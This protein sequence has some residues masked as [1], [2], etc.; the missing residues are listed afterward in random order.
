VPERV[1]C[2]TSFFIAL[3]N[4]DDPYHEKGC[5]L[6]FQLIQEK[7][8]FLLHWG[9]VLE[10]GD[11]F[12]KLKRRLAGMRL[13][14]QFFNEEI[15]V[16]APIKNDLLQEG[17]HLYQSRPDK[18]YGLTDCLSFTLMRREKIVKALTAD[19]HFQQEGFLALLLA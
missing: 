3:E 4:C 18:D 17:I 11:G 1:F 13:L 9:I 16:I 2:D 15:Y 14:E 8:I 19:Y 5:T 6:A 12:A 10:I 7:A